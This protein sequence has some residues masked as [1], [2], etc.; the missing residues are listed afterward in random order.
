MAPFEGVK[1]FFKNKEV[2]IINIIILMLNLNSIVIKAQEIDRDF[3]LT[4]CLYISSKIV[5]GT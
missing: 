1:K 2:N 3:I 5:R 4:G